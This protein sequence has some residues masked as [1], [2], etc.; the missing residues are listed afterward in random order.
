MKKKI[1]MDEVNISQ[2][3]DEAIDILRTHHT[4]TPYVLTL[5]IDFYKS[6]SK[7]WWLD[8]V[9]LH[10]NVIVKFYDE[11]KYHLLNSKGELEVV[12]DVE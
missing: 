8:C 6:L 11:G 2:V 5:H 4:P 3:L 1:N 10:D 9:K 12:E 7:E